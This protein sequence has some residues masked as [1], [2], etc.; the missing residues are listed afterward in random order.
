MEVSTTPFMFILDKL[1]IF[2][3]PVV[4]NT[5]FLEAID[6]FACGPPSP[7]LSRPQLIIKYIFILFILSCC[8]RSMAQILPRWARHWSRREWPFTE[9]SQRPSEPGQ[10]ASPFAFYCL[11]FLRHHQ[12]SLRLHPQWRLQLSISSYSPSHAHLL[13]SISRAGAIKMLY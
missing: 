4:C 12:D 1:P 10:C 6:N 9:D 7:N 5:T 8:R 11:S 13:L 2:E 3:V